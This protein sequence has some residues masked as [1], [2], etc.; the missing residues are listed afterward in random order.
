MRITFLA[1]SINISG[2]IKTI[3]GYADRFAKRGHEVSVVC[4]F[5]KIG[6]KKIKKISIL[7]PKRLLMNII[8]Y[9]PNWIDLSANIKYV[10]SFHEKY[11]P[12]G[13][14]VVATAWETAS[15]VASY[16]PRKGSKFYLFMHYEF[17]HEDGCKYDRVDRFTYKLPLRK[18]V[19]SSN[20]R[21][22]L[23]EK[24]NEDSIL[25]PQPVDTHIFYP[26]RLTYNKNKRVCMLR[27]K[28]EWKGISDG[29]KAFRLAKKKYQN[30]KLVMFGCN[31]KYDNPDGEFYYRPSNEQ[32]RKIYNSCDIFLCPSWREGF[33][34]PSA[35][36]MACK[37]A[38]VTTNHG[39]CCDYAFHEKTALVSEPKN[40]E[41]LAKNLVRLLD[42]KALLRVI[43][44]KGYRHIQKFTW[45][46]AIDKMEQYF[47]SNL[48]SI[49][50]P[51]SREGYK[52]ILIQNLNE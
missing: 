30:I 16:N 33:G 48:V 37:T 15:Y 36:A 46:Q 22:I 34:L 42:D 40:A 12:D 3:L 27:H 10:P 13:D 1:P 43:A 5:P 35:E 23:K 38:L 7:Y 6:A 52:K 17:L 31:G 51:I 11:I 18:I 29:V 41:E 28:G 25:I 14:I 50:T 44:E 20:L 39:G 47:E 8:K 2:G 21:K 24:F 19:T 45:N 9:K 49:V 32:L 4:L 26:T